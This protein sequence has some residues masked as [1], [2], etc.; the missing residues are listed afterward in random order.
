[1]PPFRLALKKKKKSF[2]RINKAFLD[3]KSRTGKSFVRA[4]GEGLLTGAAGY[5]GGSYGSYGSKAAIDYMDYQREKKAFTDVAST[6]SKNKTKTSTM[7]KSLGGRKRKFLKRGKQTKKTKTVKRNNIK[8]KKNRSTR[9]SAAQIMNKGITY[10]QETRF[11]NNA[12]VLYELQA[13]GHTSMPLKINVMQLSRALIKHLLGKLNCH[14]SDWARTMLSYGFVV[15]DVVRFNYYNSW[16]A[17]STSS[18]NVTVETPDS[19][20]RF[21]FKLYNLLKA[22]TVINRV[23]YDSYEFLPA[24]GSRFVSGVNLELAPLKVNVHVESKLKIQNQ[25]VSAAT[26]NEADDVNNAPLT[27]KIYTVKG[28]NFM[29]KGNLPLLS[30]VGPGLGTNSQ[31]EETMLK[32]GWTSNLPDIEGNNDIGYLGV[33][34]Q[35]SFLKPSEIVAKRDIQYC[36]KEQKVVINPGIV[37]TSA[38]N[39]TYQMSLSKYMDILLGSQG[40]VE[41]S[42]AY[43]PQAGITK[44]VLLEKAIGNVATKVSI[45]AEVEYKHAICI[46]GKQPFYNLPIAFQ[47][48]KAEV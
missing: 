18:F 22:T 45:R 46:T 40:A 9:M 6:L 28:N 21:A 38:I 32:G 11:T 14:V 2:N 44:V 23:R 4:V 31:Y 27:G 48:D 47:F 12:D 25:T 41:D 19:F 1:M 29:R 37:R 17:S 36:L 3:Y 43:D 39:Q 42:L 5:A 35:G 24:T 8:R 26:D 30:G 10:I 15:G 20:D 7:G 33:P 13:I 34:A 16:S